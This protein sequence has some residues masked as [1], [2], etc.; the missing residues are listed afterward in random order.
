MEKP[1]AND[2]YEMMKDAIGEK[3]ISPAMKLAKETAPSLLVDHGLSCNQ[4]ILSEDNP[5]D[6]K[7]SI[8]IFLA[9]SLA[10]KDDACIKAFTQLCDDA[11]I[12]NEE[13]ISVVRIVR[14]AA[15]SGVI[16]SSEGILDYISKR[17]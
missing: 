12:T 4:S 3:D 13:L 6:K 7:T 11:Q 10:F 14:H 5:L 16:G 9:A 8:L 1:T 15:S 17:K 2:V